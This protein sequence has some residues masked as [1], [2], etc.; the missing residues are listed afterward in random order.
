MVGR[1]AFVEFR[2]VKQGL[3]QGGVLSTLLF[4]YYMAG[5]PIWSRQLSRSNWK[6]LRTEQYAALRT[7][8]GRHLMTEEDDIVAETLM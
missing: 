7:I 8:T 3:L 1:Q 4:N 2:K 6:I 5:Q